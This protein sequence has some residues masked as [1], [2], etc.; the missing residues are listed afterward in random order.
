MPAYQ[1][2]RMHRLI[3][4]KLEAV[5]RGEIKRLMIFSPPRHGKSELV[6]RR[7]PARYIGKFPKAQFISA[8]Y[9]EELA[10]DFGRDVRNIVASQEYRQLYPDTALSH[11]SAAKGKWHTT[12]GGVY[13][14]TSV[15]K[16]I[17]GRGADVLNID[18]PVK[19]RIDA[20]SEIVRKNVWDWYASTAYTRLMPGAAIVLT[21]TRW[22]P[23]DLAGKLLEAARD[24]GDQW[25]VLNLPALAGANDPLGREPGEALWPERY[26]A[27]DLAGIRA[28]IREREFGALYQQD[29][30]PPGASYF[31]LQDLLVDGEPVE[32]PT[33]CDTIFLVIDTAVKAGKDHDGTAVS[34]WSYSTHGGHKLICLDWDIISIDGALLETWIPGALERG[35]E[36]AKVCRA[37]FGSQGAWIE[38]AQSGAILLQQCANRGL[39]AAALPAKLTSA[40]KDARA[41][42]A[43]GPVFRGDVKLSRHAYDKIATFK[44]TTRNHMVS[45]IAGF[46]IGDKHAST[47]A[48][49]LLD[50]FT[51]AVAITLG[52]QEGIA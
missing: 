6:S 17:T 38:D 18:D 22:H 30:Q 46:R 52:D 31:D 21:M 43:S 33:F 4:D 12:A 8:S 32:Y 23:D 26:S 44:G 41:I 3:C 25:D 13:I 47:R 15:G 1:I 20:E 37:R 40:G 39:P 48:D 29:P 10:T 24:G 16:G 11:D 9:G 7:W 28:N 51:Y 2:G 5:E 27:S 49:D 35:E 36:L 50:T 34:W 45:Q 19:D 42:N 14:S